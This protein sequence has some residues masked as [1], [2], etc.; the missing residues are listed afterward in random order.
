MS[1]KC[2]ELGDNGEIG[3]TGVNDALLQPSQ[4]PL[5]T[6]FGDGRAGAVLAVYVALL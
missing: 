4:V 2:R 3:A 6:L 1:S 5:G